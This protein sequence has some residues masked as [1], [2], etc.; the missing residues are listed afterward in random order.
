MNGRLADT[1]LYLNEEKH[2]E[3]SIFALLSRKENS[4]ICS[5]I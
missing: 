5:S 1:L 4:R 2:Y 3:E